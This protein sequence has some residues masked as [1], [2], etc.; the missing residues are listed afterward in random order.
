MLSPVPP[1]SDY[2]PASLDATRWEQLEPLYRGLLERPVDG[3]KALQQLLLDRSE[4]DAAVSEAGATLEINMTCHT[5]DQAANAAYTAFVEDVAPKLKTVS[6]EL[7]KKIVANPAV[8]Q[9]DS[10]RYGVLL[11][12]LRLGVELFRPE[13]VPLET[14]LTKLAQEFQQL[15]GSL[16]VRFRGEEKTLPQ[17]SKYQE[18]TDR[19]LREEAFRAVAE[20]RLQE[21]ERFDDLFD[22]MLK[23]RHQ[24]ALNA[25]FE[26][27]R[28]YAHKAKRRF[29]YTVADCDAFASS[30]EQN[31]VPAMRRLNAQR[32]EALNLSRLRPWDLSV[33]VKGRPPLKPFSTADDMVARSHR[34]FQRMDPSLG[35]LF[36]AL[37]AGVGG[38]K[39]LDLES[40]KGKAPGGYQ[41][42][43][44]RKRVP[45]IF[46]NATGVQRD[47]ETMVHEAGHAFHALL[48]RTEP[49]VA[50]RAEIPLEFCEVAS[51]SMELTSHP[52]LDEFYSAADAD[53]ARRNHLEGI[54]VILPWIAVIDQFQQWVYTHPGHTRQERTDVWVGLLRRFYADVDWSGL[55]ATRDSLWHR[56]L[57]IFTSPFYYIEYGI[58]QLGALQ[59]WANYR[60]DP[61]GAI[62][63][64]K[65]GLRLGGSRPLP[66]LFR[67]AGLHFDFSAPRVRETWKQVEQVLETL[68][69]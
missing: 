44:D 45:F 60:A 43:R 2:V 36:G 38:E 24:T 61:E 34:V 52:F 46:M 1:A 47:V 18:E 50:Y 26:N 35:T 58:A 39:C 15:A 4:L 41:A 54:A 7:D 10:E 65:A 17:M 30:V 48:C 32:A 68:P 33:D 67:A 51:M 6:F 40:R 62:R 23:I 19:S 69:V 8:A 29:D 16:T 5:D 9:L 49:L 37:K 20:R 64:Y 59:L 31:V 42:N 28:D 14:D 12:D 21:R 56:Q 3:V 27:Y 22:R 13:N 57:H 53:R 63:G 11:R 66:D 25:G 55:E